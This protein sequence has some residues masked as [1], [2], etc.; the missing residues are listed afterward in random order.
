MTFKTIFTP[1]T[2]AGVAES[3]LACAETICAANDAHLDVLCIGVD[4]TQ[5]SYF[6]AGASAII[7]QSAIEEAQKKANALEEVVKARLGRTD[8][9]WATRCAVSS[10]PDAGL[11]AARMARFAD[12]AVVPLPYGEGRGSEDHIITEAMLF[13]AAVPTLCVPDKAKDAMPSRVLIA[14]NE[15][16]EALRAVRSALPFLMAAQDVHIAVIDPPSHGPDRS[17]PGGQLAVMLSRHGVN[18]DIQVMSRNGQRVGD[19]LLR[20]ATELGAQMLVMGGY[21]HSRFREAVLGGAT[22][23]MLENA[24]IPVLMAH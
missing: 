6:E 5:T 4:R 12:L 18:C 7:I 2:N 13:N 16:A 8:I 9:R 3:A 20:S 24:E 15:S 19:V 17:D 21:E 14:W 22:R 23:Y 10:M 1:V 11:P